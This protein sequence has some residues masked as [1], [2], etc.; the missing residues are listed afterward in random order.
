MEHTAA[1]RAPKSQFGL[2]DVVVDIE[3]TLSPHLLW[4]PVCNLSRLPLLPS[5]AQSA[6]DQ[7]EL[8]RS[9]R[10]SLAIGRSGVRKRGRLGLTEEAPQY[11][12]RS[13]QGVQFPAPLLFFVVRQI[14]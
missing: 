9:V 8:S 6:T 14:S 12:R 2:N 3:L 1:P 13:R 4:H 11:T 5:V 7:R 10:V